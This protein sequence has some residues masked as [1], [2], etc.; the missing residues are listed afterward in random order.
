MKKNL[1]LLLLLSFSVSGISAAVNATI[2]LPTTAYRTY[3]GNYK[4][5]YTYDA[6]GNTTQVKYYL[7]E[8]SVYELKRTVTYEYHRLPNGKFVEKSTVGDTYRSFAEYDS[9]GMQL[10]YLGEAL[11]GDPETGEWKINERTETVVDAN[12][13]RTGVREYNY[14]TQQMEDVT[15]FTFNDK[16]LVTSYTDEDGTMSYTWSAEN[17]LTGFSYQGNE[18]NFVYQNISTVLNPEYFETYSLN[19]MGGTDDEEAHDPFYFTILD[20]NWNDY[21]LKKWAYNADVSV[22]GLV[23]TIRTDVDDNAGKVTITSS[24]PGVE[25]YIEVYQRLPYGGWTH[26]EKEDGTDV[27][28][29]SKEY[30]E[31]GLLTKDVDIYYEY[32]DGGTTKEYVPEYDAQGR[33][34][35]IAYKVN[36]TVIF[37]ETYDSWTN[38]EIT[39]VEEKQYLKAEIYPNPASN[40]IIVNIPQASAGEIVHVFDMNGSMVMSHLLANGNQIEVSSLKPGVYMLKAGQHIGKFVIR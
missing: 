32:G 25:E 14:E 5:E 36:G 29:T 26:S 8:G 34:I 33:L 39:G 11:Y 6:Y 23:G 7:E 19:P 21:E 31:Y 12:G 15:G 27:W 28:F 17:S 1:L 37:E 40:F 9:K 22:N 18:L 35:K 20:F 10:S 2:S 38:V 24:A 3:N 13:I 4:M 30:N 16:G